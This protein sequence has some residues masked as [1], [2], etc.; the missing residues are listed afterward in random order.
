MA[1]LRRRSGAETEEQ[2]LAEDPERPDI[3]V[4]RARAQGLHRDQVHVT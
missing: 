2:S 3:A 4:A 1:F